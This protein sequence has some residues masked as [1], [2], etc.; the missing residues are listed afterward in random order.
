MAP[1]VARSR[2]GLS[3][4]RSHFIIRCPLAEG[5]SRQRPMS[6]AR[7]GPP[8][9]HRRM[10]AGFNQS[11][12]IP[13]RSQGRNQA[14]ASN[15]QSGRRLRGL[16]PMAARQSPGTKSEPSRLRPD[17]GPMGRRAELRFGASPTSHLPRET[18]NKRGGAP[19]NPRHSARELV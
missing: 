3:P 10:P 14:P 1:E 6:A 17:R 16:G 19:V 5:R 4:P 7:P 13:G 12:T 15:D 11:H 2:R 18:I 9:N 8:P